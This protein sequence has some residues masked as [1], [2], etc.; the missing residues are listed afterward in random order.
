M[1]PIRRWSLAGLFACA[2][3]TTSCAASRPISSAAPPRLTL[4]ET[5][6]RPCR[7][8][9]LA[10]PATIGALEAAYVE[11]GQAIVACDQARAL[12]VEVLEAERALTDRWLK[13]D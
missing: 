3:M 2:A 8:P 9:R 11:R 13:A 1:T 4:D 7:L 6:L 10:E 5:A 12:A